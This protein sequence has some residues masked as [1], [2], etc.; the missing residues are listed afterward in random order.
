MPLLIVLSRTTIMTN[1]EPIFFA[2]PARFRAWLK[3]NHARCSQ[4][5]IG[6]HRKSSG[7]PSI[8]WPESVDE[9]LCFGWIDGLRKSV[10]ERSYKIRFTP[11]RSTSTW[12]AVN[13]RRMKEL[14]GLGRVQDAGM[15]AFERRTEDRSAIY[16]YENR[17]SARLSRS[18]E[19][20]FRSNR[21]AWDWFMKQP[22]GYRQIMTWWVV[23]A[24]R[25]ETQTK[26]LAR[27]IAESK[28]KRRIL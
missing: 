6:F 16:A 21:S 25:P 10:D 19:Q 3:K 11:R 13:A 28:K 7:L 5:W 18:A 24:K 12:S 8:T 20:Q 17:K 22:P 4:Q 1:E 23:S 2:T 27:L 15:K 14:I 26:R 9:A